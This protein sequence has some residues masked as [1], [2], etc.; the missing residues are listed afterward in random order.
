MNFKET[1][2]NTFKDRRFLS[3]LFIK[4]SFILLI[5]PVIQ[6]SWFLPFVENFLENP[7]FS[8]WSSFLDKGGS[9]F[10]F[11]YGPVMLIAYIPT[12]Y[13]GMV[14][15]D[16][17]NLA[18]FSG[19]GFRFTLLVADICLLILLI[20]QFNEFS[21]KIIT[22]YWLSP[23]VLYITYWHG[24]I[25][26]IPISL[27]FLSL[28][29]IKQEHYKA[30]GILLALSITSKY[31]MLIGVPFIFIYL[32]LNQ[33]LKGGF[34]EVLKAFS[35]STIFICVPFLFSTGFIDMVILN[36][37]VD[38]LS[39]LS[40]YLTDDLKI[41]LLPT[42]YLVFLYYSWRMLR[43]NYELLLATKAVGFSIIIFL[44]LPPAG[45]ILWLVPLYSLHQSKTNGGANYFIA[46]FSFFFISYHLVYSS[47]A[48]IIP[49]NFVP[50]FL[51]LI[52]NYLESSETKS[53]FNTLIASLGFLLGIQIFREG[54]QGNDY[55]NLGKKPLVIGITGDSGTGKST[56]A[57]GL[58]KLF[59][60]SATF[61]LEGDDYHKWD[62]ESPEWESKTHLNPEANRLF[63]LLN[64]L[65]GVL[66]G[67][68]LKT[69]SYDHITG[70]FSSPKLKSSK[71]LILIS[72]L[73]TLYLRDLVNEM[74]KSFFLSMDE[75]LRVALKVRRDSD[76][77][78]TE[79]YT[80]DQIEKRKEDFKR[81]IS[82][83][84]ERADVIF[85]ILPEKAE[86]FSNEDKDLNNVALKLKVIIKSCSYYNELVNVLTEECKLNVNVKDINDIGG[87]EIEIIGEALENNIKRC[88][89][90]LA[91]QMNELIDAKKGFSKGM[92]GIMELITLLEINDDVRAK[93]RWK[94]S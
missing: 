72:G 55:Y 23:L 70:L 1:I 27:L 30:G 17:L 67:N 22:Y 63:D 68:S 42:I 84:S 91:P 58:T 85:K 62:R 41:Y 32:W 19:L 34:W 46:L 28:G 65:R 47:G 21:K 40:I 80:L 5:S 4:I 81:F 83:Q 36:R 29:F 92:L 48:N 61:N 66:D 50:D 71:N 88:S 15:D 86:S 39:T 3:G 87:V 90:I 74:D 69:R 24:Q 25:D 82:P 49:L 10:A 20:E 37:E 9:S 51:N 78:R 16:L 64:D 94:F 56:F 79:E 35:L 14:F 13:L 7:S 31:S 12:T 73:H 2:I 38:K 54:I 33:N 8:P 6:H 77:G 11:P 43:M 18:Y 44:T 52:P 59:G 53:I 76:R 26:I 93:R 45:W 89:E 57:N 60:T 75:G